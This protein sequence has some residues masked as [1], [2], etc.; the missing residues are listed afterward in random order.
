M[1]ALLRSTDGNPDSRFEKYVDF[2]EEKRVPNLT[3][4]WDR[5]SN[6][7]EGDTRFYYRRP[8]KYGKRYGNIIGLIGFNKYIF[9]VLWKNRKRYKIIHA[10]D[11]DTIIPAILIRILLGKKVIY[12]I[13]DWY[14]DSRGIQGLMKY[15][16]YLLEFFNIKLSSSVIVCELER[17]K[18][19]LFK[20]QKLW[21]LPNIPNMK[22]ALP[23]VPPNE[24][25]TIAYVGILGEA[26]GLENLV[27]YAKTHDDVIIKVAGFGPLESLFADSD[28]YPNIIF[29]GS[30][31]YSEALNIMNSADLIMA[32]YD[33][34]N[35][36]HILAAPNKYYEGLCLGKPTITI[37]G[38]IP[39]ERTKRDNT[40]YAI[41]ESYE[42]FEKLIGSISKDSLIEKSNNAAK[43][44]K[45]KYEN[46]VQDFL[47]KTYLPFIMS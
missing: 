3:I 1:V 39:G 2:L 16:V 41:E 47:N 35:P 11:F 38:T 14:V 9:N 28:K 4:C 8:S 37:L 40:G 31:K 23:I 5:F 17:V 18:Q 33:K 32:V 25:L 36:N 26:R 19:I 10:C 12:D 21:I 29:Y 45:A 6:K 43:L 46:Y 22:F 7:I 20:P 30:V 27:L 34:T 13:F 44:W 42:D 15:P 24:K